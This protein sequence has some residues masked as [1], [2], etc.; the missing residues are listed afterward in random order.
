MNE[1]APY[2]LVVTRPAERQLASLAEGPAAAIVEFM[3]GALVDNPRRVGAPLQRELDGLHSA[4]RG[5]YRIV[6]EIL[7][8]DHLVVVHRIDHR[9]TIYRSR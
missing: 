6:Y 7:D 8:A 3:L 5:V 9:S 4:R 2:R 1:A